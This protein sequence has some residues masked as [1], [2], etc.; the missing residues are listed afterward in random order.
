MNLMSWNCRGLGNPRTVRQIRRWYSSL[1]PD[2]LFLSE[3][4]IKKEVAEKLKERVGFSNAIGVSSIGLSGGLCL[5]WNED[6]ISFTLVSFSQNHICGDI[7]S[8]GGKRWRFIGLYG[9]P[10]EFNKHKTWDLMRVL[11]EHTQLPI[12]VGGDF[13]E[14]LE[15][16]EKEGGAVEIGERWRVLGRLW[17]ILG[18]EI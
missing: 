16:G 4:K 8:K 5:M 15:Y 18:W 10:E 2:M 6:S 1:A 12:V 14:I 9:W 17:R 3:T 13:N 7:I 11:C